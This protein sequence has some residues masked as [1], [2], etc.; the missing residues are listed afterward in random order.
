MPAAQPHFLDA[1]GVRPRI[2]RQRRAQRGEG[3]GVADHGDVMAAAGQRPGQALDADAVAAEVV[4]RIERRDEA[5]AAA[6]DATRAAA[7]PARPVAISRRAA[8]MASAV[9]V[10]VR[11]RSARAGGA[12]RAPG[13]LVTAQRGHRRRQALDIAG[14]DEQPAAGE[15]FRQ[16][17][18]GGGDHRRPASRGFHRRQPEAFRGGRQHQ[19]EGAGVEMPQFRRR[20]RSRASA[21]ARPSPPRPPPGGSPPR[22]RGRH[23]RRPGRPGAGA[24]PRG[25]NGA[26]SARAR[27]P[28]RSTCLCGLKPP[29]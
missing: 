20:G 6:H 21:P 7:A 26:R 14:C 8:R 18:G 13:G 2:G 23:P 12:H 24:A 10:Q 9:R 27:G 22:C 19:R 29:T 5:E 4:G 15:Q 17:A 3:I 16:R 25:R 1:A 28:A 11:R